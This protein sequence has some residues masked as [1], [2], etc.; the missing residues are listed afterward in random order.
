MIWHLLLRNI[1]AVFT[2]SSHEALSRPLHPFQA[3]SNLTKASRH[4]NHLLLFYFLRNVYHYLKMS[5][6]FHCRF[7]FCLPFSQLLQSRNFAQ[8]IH[9]C[10]P[11]A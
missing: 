2:Y 9:S 8:Y 3:T 4:S 1:Q 11:S 7:V 10:I 5:C 6:G